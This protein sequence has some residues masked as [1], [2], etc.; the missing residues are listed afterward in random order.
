MTINVNW[1]QAWA[2]LIQAVAALGTLA[3]IVWTGYKTIPNWQNQRQIDQ[4]VGAAEKIL[5]LMAQS[6]HKF[7]MG[8]STLTDAAGWV[9]R[10]VDPTS[11]FFLKD[12]PEDGNFINKS[13]VPDILAAAELLLEARIKA[14]AN[15]GATAAAK[16]NEIIDALEGVR[17]IADMPN[18]LP[19]LLNDMTEMCAQFSNYVPEV[20]RT[21][22]RAEQAYAAAEAALAVYLGRND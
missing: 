9:A 1:V 2:A 16:I 14:R 19:P 10:S 5:L 21:I 15:F 7:D 20:A 12:V 22:A 8:K 11:I 13:G 4:R 18:E 6:Q 3:A 17:Y